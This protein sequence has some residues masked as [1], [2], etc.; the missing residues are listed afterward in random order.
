MELD[1]SLMSLDT[2]DT[3]VISFR[4]VL[5]IEVGLVGFNVLERTADFGQSIET[6]DFVIVLW[7]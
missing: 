7:V 6:L 2:Q 1:M 4:L 3:E 5:L